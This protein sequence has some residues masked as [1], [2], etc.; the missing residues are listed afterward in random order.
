MADFEFDKTGFVALRGD[1][2]A[3]GVSSTLGNYY[4]GNY[5]GGSILVRSDGVVL[6]T[7]S[8]STTRNSSI[9]GGDIMVSHVASEE[10]MR[11]NH[12]SAAA[13]EFRLTTMPSSQVLYKSRLLKLDNGDFLR[14]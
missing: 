10:V 6:A 4:G 8:R 12:N 13:N 9:L 14:W 2:Q 11:T 7:Y 1:F 3:S 5:T